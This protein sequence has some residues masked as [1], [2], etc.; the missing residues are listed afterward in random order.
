MLKQSVKAAVAP[1]TEQL[2]KTLVG[3]ARFRLT[4]PDQFLLRERR[5]VPTRLV[6]ATRVSQRCDKSISAAEVIRS[7]ESVTG[8]ATRV[9]HVG[10]DIHRPVWII[11]SGLT[12][13]TGRA[14]H[15]L[16]GH[17]GQKCRTV[18]R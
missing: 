14:R 4:K 6:C 1:H 7:I 15:R 10:D 16:A 5:E 2:L 17:W 18:S 12:V 8:G 13:N 9:S 3:E 11:R